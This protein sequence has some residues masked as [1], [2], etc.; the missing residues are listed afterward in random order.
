MYTDRQMDKE[1]VVLHTMECYSGNPAICNDADELGGHFLL[2][3]ISQ[4][5]KKY[6]MNPL[7][8]VK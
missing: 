2:S 1:N 3:E 6:C 7:I 8:Y 5:Q 4:S